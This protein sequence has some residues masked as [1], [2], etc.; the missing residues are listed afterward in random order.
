MVSSVLAP[1][2]EVAVADTLKVD[3]REYNIFTN[4]TEVI[5]YQPSNGIPCIDTAEYEWKTDKIC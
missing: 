1:G 4:T 2:E 5:L 3:I